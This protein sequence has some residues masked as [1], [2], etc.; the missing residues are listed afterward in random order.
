M[1]E[2]L[3]QYS[4]CVVNADIEAMAALTNLSMKQGRI[5]VGL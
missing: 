3:G 2:L 4:N 5:C 1:D